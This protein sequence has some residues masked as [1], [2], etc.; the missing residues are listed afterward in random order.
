MLKIR[1]IP[2]VSKQQRSVPVPPLLN[3]AH[4][5]VIPL[6]CRGAH[7]VRTV[8]QITKKCTTL[9]LQCVYSHTY[10]MPSTFTLDTVAGQL[11]E[12]LMLQQHYKGNKVIYS[13]ATQ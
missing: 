9:A 2:L 7:S 13:K 11:A 1:D 8:I 10:L 12:E 5:R 4:S 3:F 6:V